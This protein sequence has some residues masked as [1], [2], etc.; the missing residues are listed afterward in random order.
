MFPERPDVEK[1][2]KLIDRLADLQDDLNKKEYTYSKLVAV[3]VRKAIQRGAKT[4]ELDCVKVLGNDDVEKQ[5]L[6][7]L[8]Q[9]IFDRKKDIR[10]V[11]G[12]IEAWKA[13]K[14]LYRTDSYHQVTGTPDGSF[15]DKPG[16]VN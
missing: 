14:D 11:W 1:F 3:N 9:E 15:F 7:K 16:D 10:M 13:E 8:Q 12:A 2:I 4:R 5:V 6:D